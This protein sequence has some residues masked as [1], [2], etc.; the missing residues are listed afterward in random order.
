MLDCDDGNACTTD[1]CVSGSGCAH[2]EAMSLDAVRCR[3]ASFRDA[4][5][6]APSSQLNAKLVGKK[7][8]LSRAL[9][10]CD[11]AVN[12]AQA[13]QRHGV[14]RRIDKRFNALENQLQRLILQVDRGFGNGLL[15]ASLRD[16]L[17]TLAAQAASAARSPR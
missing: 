12:A 11:Q 6:H 8:K 15:A 17:E 13:A 2:T 5:T 10:R 16:E 7:G 1:L 9:G 14:K 4:I 3:L